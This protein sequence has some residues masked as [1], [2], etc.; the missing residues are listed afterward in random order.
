MEQDL[1]GLHYTIY[2]WEEETEVRYLKTCDVGIMPLSDEPFNRGKCGFKLIQYMACGLPTI[3]TPMEANVKINR[4]GN[5]LFATTPE[6][7]LA[8]F[9]NHA[10]K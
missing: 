5:N 2:D 8:L 6:E 4:D 1:T 10:D 9:C 3:S 7:W